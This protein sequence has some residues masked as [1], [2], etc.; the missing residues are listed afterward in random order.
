MTDSHEDSKIN[1]IDPTIERLVNLPPKA[2]IH[3]ALGANHDLRTGLDELI[4][5]SIDAG[6]KTIAVV[7]HIDELRL[8]QISVHDDGS[9]MTQT[10]LEDVLSLGGHDAHSERNIGRYGMGLKEGSFANASLSTVV[11]RPRGQRTSGI[12]ISKESFQAGVLD[13]ASANRVWN[14]RAGLI[15]LKSGTSIVWN[16]LNNVYRGTDDME[17]REFFGTTIESAR[18]HIGIRYHRFL[19]SDRLAINLYS[20]FDADSPRKTGG[21]RAI[22]P[23][24]YRRSGNRAYPK[25]LTVGADPSAPGIVAHIWPNRS[26]IDQ[27]NLEG[28]DELGH[29]G[30]YFYDADRLITQGGW[31][32]YRSPN[33]QWKMLR[34]I[35][36]D[37]RVID[38]YVTVSPQKGS[39]RLS[40]EF[41]RFIRSLKM[42]GDSGNG[43]AQVLDDAKRTLSDSNKKSGAASP[44]ADT[45]EGIAR[46]VQEAVWASERLKATDPIDFEWGKTDDEKLIKLEP[47]RNRV[48]LNENYREYL[49]RGSSGPDDAP[50]LKALIYLLFNDSLSSARWTSKADSNAEL[51]TSILD[52][53]LQEEMDARPQ[54]WF[55]PSARSPRKHIRGR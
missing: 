23:F 25:S 55:N 18:K 5:N 31:S 54:P 19:D 46:R 17:A 20:Q 32:G 34:I 28:R 6:A 9:G 38:E 33:K 36:D 39:V 15:D 3:Q 50:L 8:V 13:E 42:P 53:A 11:S 27:F 48:I 14:L 52:A 45:G 1:Q 16:R 12:R 30:F 7:F 51:W 43:F 29:Q 10:T 21:V 47:S 26:K 41:D 4:D 2:A 24:A 44:L 35:V 40:E 49:N 22:D 37:P